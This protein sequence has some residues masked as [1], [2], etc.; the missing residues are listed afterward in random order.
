MK[1]ILFYNTPDT[2]RNFIFRAFIIVKLPAFILQQWSIELKEVAHLCLK[3]F[4]VTYYFQP[5]I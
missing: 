4:S 3:W 5:E 1:S 2:L